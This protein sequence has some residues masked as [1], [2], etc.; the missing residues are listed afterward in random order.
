M[1]PNYFGISFDSAVTSVIITILK[2]KKME[3]ISGDIFIVPNSLQA[4]GEYP[5]NSR[6]IIESYE[7]NGVHIRGRKV[8]INESDLTVQVWCG[9]SGSDNWQDHGTPGFKNDIY[10]VPFIGEI[11]VKCLDGLRETDNFEIV[12]RGKT[13][14]L[15][16][17]QAE[18]RYWTYGHGQFHVLLQEL[19][20]KYHETHK[21]TA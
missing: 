9:G 13:F 16:C 15:T 4:I 7:D 6:Y 8:A 18:S 1:A 5:N 12:F 3:P 2:E 19:V 17:R 20:D 14:R 10:N 11:P 21:K